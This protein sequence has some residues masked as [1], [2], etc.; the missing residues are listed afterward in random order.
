MAWYA[1]ATGGS[2]KDYAS[3]GLFEAAYDG[4]DFSATDGVRAE[5]YGEI[6]TTEVYWTGWVTVMSA[7]CKILVEAAVGEECDGK[8]LSAGARYNSAWSIGSNTGAFFIDTKFL[9][10]YKATGRN[11]AVGSDFKSG[12]IQFLN[13]L[14]YTDAKKSVKTV[15]VLRQSQFLLNVTKPTPKRCGLIY[16]YLRTSYSYSYSYSSSA[17]FSTI[18]ML[19]F[20]ALIAS[21]SA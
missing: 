9:T 6:G 16:F 13:C 20:P 4:E 10:L 1:D 21:S 3:L 19:V 5:C 8:D 11:F 14:F 18:L 17:Y 7:S 2:D 12:T 15:S